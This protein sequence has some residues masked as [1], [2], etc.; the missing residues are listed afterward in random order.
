[1]DLKDVHVQLVRQMSL[2]E[3]ERNRDLI[4]ALTI[5]RLD[6]TRELEMREREK[7]REHQ[8]WLFDVGGE[9]FHVCSSITVSAPCSIFLK[10]ATP[11]EFLLL[12]P[13]CLMVML[14]RGL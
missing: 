9:A 7:E 5:S 4:Q 1:M 2:P 12:L 8:R 13:L 11:S 14:P 3:S 6:L 10:K